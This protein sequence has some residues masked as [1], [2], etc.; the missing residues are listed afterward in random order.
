MNDFKRFWIEG[1]NEPPGAWLSLFVTD[2]EN[3]AAATL[4]DYRE[5][6][7]ESQYRLVKVE[8]AVVEL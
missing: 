8:K 2:D 6:D 3:V 7:P 1:W 5:S 4:A